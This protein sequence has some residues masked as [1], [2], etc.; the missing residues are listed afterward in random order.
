MK[1]EMAY[2]LMM[3]RMFASLYGGSPM[4]GKMEDLEKVVKEEHPWDRI[5]LPKKLRKG[6]TYEELQKLRES[7]WLESGGKKDESKI[8]LQVSAKGTLTVEPAE[9]VKV[10]V[11]K[12]DEVG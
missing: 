9:E 3:A 10:E 5:D 1:K 7:I 6:K 11:I 4:E 8:G 2:S 12:E